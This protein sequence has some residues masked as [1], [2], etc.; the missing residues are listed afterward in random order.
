M[1]WVPPLGFDPYWEGKWLPLQDEFVPSINSKKIFL[2]KLQTN[3][4]KTKNQ[5][6]SKTA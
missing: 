4:E 6:F 1:A 5:I 2:Q 3:F